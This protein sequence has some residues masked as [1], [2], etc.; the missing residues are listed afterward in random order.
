MFVTDT[1]LRIQKECRRGLEAAAQ[2]H[3][4]AI[5]DITLGKAALRSLGAIYRDVQF[6]LIERL[7]DA[8]VGQARHLAELAQQPVREYPGRL[9]IVAFY[10]YIDG[11][12]NA[13]VQDLRHHV[14][15]QEI[16][17]YAGKL[18]PRLRRSC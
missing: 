14:G 4:H 8:K 7:L 18:L 11:R 3:Q 10:L 9:D 17:G 16:E 2:R 6:G 15:R 13:E 5:G 1:V 12:R